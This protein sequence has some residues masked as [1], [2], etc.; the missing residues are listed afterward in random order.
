MEQ[1]NPPKNTTASVCYM[2]GSGA[3]WNG[4]A[5]TDLKPW[6]TLTIVFDGFPESA[7]L[8][9]LVLTSQVDS[10]HHGIALNWPD[11]EEGI[12]RDFMFRIA[13]SGEPDQLSGYRLTIKNID[14]T[15]PPGSVGPQPYHISL[16]GLLNEPGQQERAWIVDPEVINDPQ[17]P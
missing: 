2:Q 4:P 8:Q 10:P 11:E 7:N 16:T 5:Q 12:E 14:M 3:Q 6:D 15:R 13:A 9:Q 1:E 17:T